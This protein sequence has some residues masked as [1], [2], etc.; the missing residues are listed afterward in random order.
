MRE[1]LRLLL[2]QQIQRQKKFDRT[3]RKKK[4]KSLLYITVEK[5]VTLNSVGYLATQK[6][7][8]IK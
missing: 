8:Q 6:L 3:L 2:E 4:V 5:I 1:E 7:V